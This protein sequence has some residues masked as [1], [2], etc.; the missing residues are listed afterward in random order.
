MAA[1]ASKPKPESTC[2]IVGI[3]LGGT[4]AKL[5]LLQCH[6]NATE[7][8]EDD[9]RVVH[10]LRAPLPTEQADRYGYERDACL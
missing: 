8:R 10:S 1:T 6:G 9:G 7:Q 3:D 4:A 2:W 5:G